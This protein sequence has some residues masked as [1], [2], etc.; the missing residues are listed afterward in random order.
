[1]T[2]KQISEN[3]VN[4]LK[5]R[6]KELTCLLRMADIAGE[7]GISI[8]EILRQTLALLIPAWQ[9]SDV[10]TARI[11]LDG[12]AHTSAGF[13]EGVSMQ[14]A[15]ITVQGINRGFVEVHYVKAMPEQDEGP[16]LREERRL[17]DA[18]ARQVGV[19]VERKQAEVERVQLQSQLRHADRL[20]TIGF[21]AA[22]VAHELNE[23]LGNILGF[24]ELAKK[25]TGLPDAAHRDLTK[26]ETA[27]LH[28]REIIKKLLVFAR[29]MPMEKTAVDINQV[30]REGLFFL[31]ARCMKAGIEV[32]YA[33]ADALPLI[34]ADA[35]QI[36]QV[37][38]N[39]VVNALQ[40]MPSGGTLHVAT[41]AENDRVCMSVEDTGD[42]MSPEVQQQV[43]VPFFTTK[44]V[45][46][47]T[48]LGLP[49]VHGI[50]VSHGGTIEI[51]SEVG[52]GTRIEIWLPVS[53]AP[54]L[55]ETADD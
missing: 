12:Q 27:S 20:A 8:E 4:T 18:V 5:E 13:S 19:I 35:A 24:A 11:I 52:R 42:G 51:Q 45:G 29:Q 9:H 54:I 10:A 1:M 3:V 6:V 31:E 47:G 28:A 46:Q 48:G 55:E 14:R 32:Q 16:F 22:G 41:A 26:I 40:A 39:L 43:F 21:L 23:P 36:N 30:V 34:V 53:P 25:C 49:V 17:I 38:V 15:D 50:V 7:P 37:L 33:L 44:D 2:Q